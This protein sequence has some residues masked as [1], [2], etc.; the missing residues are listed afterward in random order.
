M[1]TSTPPDNTVLVL[2]PPIVNGQTT[3]VVDAHI[4]MSLL[5]YDLINDGKGAVVLVD[6]P[7]KGTMDPGDVMELW[8]EG[9]AAALDSKTIEYPDV[10]TTLRIPKG[11]LHP[12]KV[13]ELYYT[14]T[15]ASNNQDRSTPSLEILYNRIRP[16][17]KDRY[18]A[19]GGHSELELLLPDVIRNGVDPDFVNAQ[20][21]VSYPY[22]RAYDSIT[23]KCN[24]EQMTVK[25]KPTEA[26]PPPNPGS[27]VPIS[28]HFTVDR[29]FLDKA[30]RLDQKLHFSYTVT[31]QI[32]NGPDTDAPWSP[33]QTVDEDLDGTRLP[34]PI[35]LERKE[36]YPGD[37]AS[38]ID[39]EKLAGNPLLLV[40]VTADSRFV[41]GYDVNATYT[42]TLPGQA[43]VVVA[44]S[45]KVEADPFG[46]KVT[47]VLEV[48][49]DK[50]V[51][52][53]TVTATYQL[54]RPNGDLVGSSN[55]AKATVTGTNPIELLPPFLVAP[56]VSP[57]DVRAYPQG[58]TIRVEYLQA[59]PGDRA[60]LVELNPPPGA[61]QFPLVDFNSNKRTNTKLTQEFLAARQGKALDLRW[62]LN[63]N[64]QQAGRSTELNL[65]ILKLPAVLFFINAPYLIAPA[66]RLK[67]VVIRVGSEAQPIAD[68]K[69]TLTLPDG[70]R[71]ADGGSGDR[72]FISDALGL[73]TV[74]D[75]KGSSR[76]GE[77]ALIATHAG[78]TESA[79][80]VVKAHG[81]V[82][83]IEMVAQPH[84]IIFSRDGKRAYVGCDSPDS[85]AVIDTASNTVIDRYLVGT[86]QYDFALSP[87]DKFLY[88]TAVLNARNTLYI[89]E[90][91]TGK[92]VKTIDSTQDQTH[93]FFK[94][95]GTEFFRC[96]NGYGISL[97]NTATELPRSLATLKN[98][99][100]GTFTNDGKLLYVCITTPGS[101][102]A[103][104]ETATL[105]VLRNITIA[106]NASYCA[107]SPDNSR[108]YV[109]H[110][111]DTPY[112]GVTVIDTSND[113]PITNIPTAQSRHLVLSS[114]GDFLYVPSQASQSVLVI[115]TKNFSTRNIRAPGSFHG[116]ALTPDDSRLFVCIADSRAID[117]FQIDNAADNLEWSEP[118]LQP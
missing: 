112:P 25:V 106:P 6:P 52:G 96:L 88:V 117:V 103:V 24:G 32:G 29:A 38:I 64:N 14:V 97:T 84:T 111:S 55:T 2:K 36:D 18:D 95:D 70:F 60:R 71:Y 114:D 19:P 39:L 89:L 75:I 78:R 115:D 113:K 41:V 72:E 57:I 85:I 105:K 7:L 92:T 116:L 98:P 65:T 83:R 26:P 49:N 74:N 11:R 43:D 34:M 22:C 94:P 79:T 37:D 54:R 93:I 44:V 50:V 76:P 27:E 108:L 99:A 110:Y 53:S 67:E 77:V 47:C 21:S 102:V 104:I 86:A 45:G 31:D 10:R 46:T 58:V 15:R 100:S 4:G 80:V 61:P 82:G 48:P 23:L 9:E 30:K 81:P 35:L 87:D 91:A 62:N 17:L 13:N 73:I 1:T 3:P 5:A 16:G 107:L 40:I 101:S 8:L 33:V 90:A 42:A 109:V 68:A 59:L 118:G 63:R 56:A 12:D 69:V 20:V 51:P 66:G 28:I